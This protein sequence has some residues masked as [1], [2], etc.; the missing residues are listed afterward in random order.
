MRKSI[1]LLIVSLI[2][3]VFQSCS[4]KTGTK[5]NE[6]IS[7]NSQIEQSDSM[8]VEQL[9]Q[10]S[11]VF[12]KENQ[13][14]IE[15]FDSFLQEAQN[16]AEQHNLTYYQAVIH[17]II[18]QR[19]RNISNFG[20]ALKLHQKALEQAQK[21]NHES[22]LSE[23]FNN[24]GIVYLQIDNSSM[25]L[26]MHI[27]ALQLAEKLND[28][29][30]ISIAINGIGA[31]NY[32]L[33]RYHTSIEYFTKSLEFSEII[34]DDRV[35]AINNKNIGDCW[36]KLGNSDSALYYQFKCLDYFLKC[37]DLSGKAACFN[38]ISASYID[39]EDLKNALIYIEKAIEINDEQGNLLE[40][41][42][43]L[44]RKGEIYYK[45]KKYDEVLKNITQALKISEDIN[46]KNQI[47]EAIRLMA[48]V[49][50]AKGNF[51]EALYYYKMASNYR[52]IIINEKNLNHLTTMEIILDSETQKQKII[53][54]SNEKNLQDIRLMRKRLMLIILV[55]S[56]FIIILVVLFLIFQF[57]LRTKYNK[58]KY[59]QRLLRT[60]MN[61]HFIFNA[62]GAI[63]VYMLEN[64]IESSTRYLTDFSKLMRQILQSS[65]SNYIPLNEEIEMIT[66]YLNLQKLR[67][68]PS[69][70]FSI[71]I[72]ENIS[73]EKTIVPP[74]IMQ[75]F[76]ENA[77][78]HGISSFGQE[79]IINISYKNIDKQIIMEVDD[80]GIGINSTSEKSNLN[81]NHESLA[82]KITKKRL[83]V[84]RKETK[85]KTGLEII[86]KKELN[87]F[88]RGTKI[89][90]IL[91][92]IEFNPKSQDEDD[93]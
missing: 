29:L 43:N 67:F 15:I 26:E 42:S 45:M 89:K 18:G 11:N 84:I 23:T 68:I 3:F 91:P 76:V 73:I 20:E 79:G 57:K 74:M 80:N 39:K 93:Q 6:E 50:E 72:D 92:L 77:I 85:G 24:L 56:T 28:S 8:I 86:D 63:K 53:E 37:D 69:F 78:E 38:C 61:P 75:P 12:Y 33:G 52:E 49:N 10:R 60:Q 4:E 32:Y 48:M 47:V 13:T 1:K 22:L 35:K 83:D 64:D 31:V 5:I 19:K 59:Q 81:K 30:N 71:Y 40:I 36:L 87:P 44:L 51:S 90:I 16:I 46:S 25:A 7:Q 66:F 21:I 41:A 70:N 17:N 55:V 82:I 14:K 9:I 27:N 54:L 62:L 34:N 58:L 2:P 65:K 88:D